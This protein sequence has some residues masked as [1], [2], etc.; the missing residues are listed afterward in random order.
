[1]PKLGGFDERCG[2]E[3]LSLFDMT[4]NKNGLIIDEMKL[5]Y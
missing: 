1:M 4:A 3:Q 2:I 5:I